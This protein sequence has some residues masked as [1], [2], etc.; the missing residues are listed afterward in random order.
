MASDKVTP[1]QQAATSVR[2]AEGKLW[3]DCA[4]MSAWH[5]RSLGGALRSTQAAICGLQEMTGVLLAFWQSRA[6]DSLTAGQ[7]LA[8]CDSPE[9]ALEIQL[10]YAGAMLQAGADEFVR[11]H[12][13]GGRILADVLVPPARPVVAAKTGPAPGAALAA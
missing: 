1:I 10:E 7:Q 13:L 9:A 6:K 2:K 12:A 8:A 4:D 3:R 11:L 5:R